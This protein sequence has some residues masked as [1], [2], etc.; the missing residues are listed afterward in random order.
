MFTIGKASDIGIKRKENQDAIG[1]WLPGLLNRQPPLLIVADGM[2]GHQEGALAAQMV[3][4]AMMDGYHKTRR[5][6]NYAEVLRWCVSLAF[7]R[8]HDYAN[9]KPEIATMGSTVVAVIL[10]KKQAHIVNVGDSRA[11]LI[12]QNEIRQISFD[13]SFVAEQVRL[14]LIRPEEAK[15]HPKRNL[16]MQSISSKRGMVEPYLNSVE[17]HP[18]D[19]IL[20]CSDGLWGTVPDSKIQ[21]VVLELPPQ[22]ASDKLVEL[23]NQNKGPDNISVMIGK[24]E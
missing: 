7:K 8:I 19:I 13:H 11:Y 23:A 12:N 20:L 9:K 2:G 3:V 10:D 5:E 24:V 16:L 1:V 17:L 22:K 21:D 18:G 6:R 14:G 4:K 15:T